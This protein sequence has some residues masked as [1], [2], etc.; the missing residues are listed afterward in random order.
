MQGSLGAVTEQEQTNCFLAVP[1]LTSASS[2]FS[3]IFAL[4]G[5]PGSCSSAPQSTRSASGHAEVYVHAGKGGRPRTVI[6]RQGYTEIVLAAIQHRPPEEHVFPQ[7]PD[8]LDVHALRREFAQGLYQEL[9]GHPLPPATGR[10][11]PSDYDLAAVEIVSKQL[12]HNRKDVVLT[13][14]LR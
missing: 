2:T 6:A 13:H 5:A 9:S 11:R 4:R 3:P 10:L 1:G 7:V 8:R 14:Y 12:G